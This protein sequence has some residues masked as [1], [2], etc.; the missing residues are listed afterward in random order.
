M[1][2]TAAI[3]NPS[4]YSQAFLTFWATART[5]RRTACGTASLANL[6]EAYSVPTGF[7]AE[8]QSKLRPRS[9]D[10]GFS[11]RSIRQGLGDNVAD[12]DQPVLPHQFRGV[13]VQVMSARIGNF[14][15]NCP[16]PFFV[17]GPLRFSQ[18]GL[19]FLEVSKIFDLDAV[20]QRGQ[21]DQAKVDANFACSAGLGLSN[22]DL[23]AKIPALTSVLRKASG[24]DFAAD[25]AT[26]PE[27][28]TALK[29]DHRAPLELDSAR[30]REWNP[31]EAFLAP[32]LWTP[33][34]CISINDKLLADGL[35]SIA[36]QT[37]ERATPNRQLD[38]IKDTRP[39]LFL[40]SRRFL[41]LAAIIPHVVDRA[42]MGTEAVGGGRILNAVSIGQD[43]SSLSFDHNGKIGFPFTCALKGLRRFCC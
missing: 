16:H 13:D 23:K 26:V 11:L 4:S 36:M 2:S 17:G 21:C 28:I 29:I 14:R 1:P 20:R 27:P 12:N 3:A 32:P 30:S 15:M 9:I 8:L 24:L 25:G 19:V 38:E 10:R 40:T 41:D 7:I 22:V 37:N 31:T 34:R 35:H 5:A 33:L 6:D 18:C 39:T 42:G 43:H